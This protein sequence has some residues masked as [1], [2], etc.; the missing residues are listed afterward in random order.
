MRSLRSICCTAY[1]VVVPSTSSF[2]IFVL[3]F[4]FWAWAKPFF[5]FL[6][7]NTDGKQMVR[8]LG[9]AS[10]ESTMSS[11]GRFERFE[12]GAILVRCMGRVCRVAL[13]SCPWGKR[14]INFLMA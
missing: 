3:V 1:L 10:R 13:A 5:S 4:A 7:P 14:A 9:K 6:A 2:A 11:T 12:G 8:W